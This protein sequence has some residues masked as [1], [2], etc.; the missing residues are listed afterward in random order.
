MDA[1]GALPEGMTMEETAADIGDPWKSP[2]TEIADESVSR[3]IRP[4]LM[5]NYKGSGCREL[6]WYRF[7]KS[8][9]YGMDCFDLSTMCAEICDERYPDPTNVCFY[10]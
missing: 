3:P 8:G 2:N 10:W 6:A 7:E 4:A 9:P 5:M 1:N